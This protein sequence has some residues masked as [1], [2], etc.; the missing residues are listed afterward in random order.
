MRYSTF[1]SLL[2][3]GLCAVINA[4][5]ILSTQASIDPKI[6]S[7]TL[8]SLVGVSSSEVQETKNIRLGKRVIN[9]A[10]MDANNHHNEQTKHEGLE[11]AAK[12]MAHA[13]RSAAAT[14]RLNREHATAQQEGRYAGNG[15]EWIRGEQPHQDAHDMNNAA[16]GH[17]DLLAKYHEQAAL[18]HKY[19]AMATKKKWDAEDAEKAGN[20]QEAEK[21]LQDQVTYSKGAATNKAA[22]LKLSKHFPH[23]QFQHEETPPSTP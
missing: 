11:N 14:N 10:A 22:A 21:H 5:P 23:L 17:M 8:T 9:K 15:A 13:Y 4:A 1:G 20:S 7:H 16:A 18:Y 19:S 2:V 6:D 12:A 3:L